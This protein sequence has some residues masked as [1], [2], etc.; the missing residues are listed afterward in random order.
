MPVVQYNG[1]DIHHF[2]RFVH[3][4]NKDA[5]KLTLPPTLLREDLRSQ[6]FPI[7]EPLPGWGIYVSDSER[8][9]TKMQKSRRPFPQLGRP[10]SAQ[11]RRIR[12][13]E[14]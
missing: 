5:Q 8:Q 1:Y 2:I 7:S 13:I 3:N 12:K 14:A 11:A 10:F 4:A 9:R 6:S